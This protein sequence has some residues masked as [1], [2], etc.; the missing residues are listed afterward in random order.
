MA[1]RAAA[2]VGRQPPQPLI[3]TVL[4]QTVPALKSYILRRLLWTPP[5][6]LVVSL[7]VFFLLRHI[8]GD[9]AQILLGDEATPME[10]VATRASLQL[11]Q[12]VVAQYL[13]WL[14]RVLHADLGNSYATGEAVLPL[15]LDRFQVSAAI[16]LASVALALIIAVPLGLLSA[17]KRNT[18]LDTAI[19]ATSSLLLSLPTFWLGLL[20]L[21][22]FGVKLGWVSAIGYVPLGDDWKA[23][24]GFLVLPVATLTLIELGVLIRLT[25]ASAVDVLDLEYVAHA[26]AKG[27]SEQ[28]VIF[29]HVLPNAIAPTLTMVGLILSNLLGGVAALET[30][31][32][33]PGLGRLLVDSIF[34]RDYPVVQGCLLFTACGYVFVNLVV[35]LSYPLLDRRISAP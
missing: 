21:L 6:L 4:E 3:L 20:L 14:G 32:T 23:A 15:I 22:V 30:V 5:T 19:G 1:T 33:L 16:V 29:R 25:R 31:F 18:F 35:D 34:S 11:D 7:L 9:P 2:R 24:I 12:P 13:N 8:P 26:R 10:L 27:L 17:W 28:A